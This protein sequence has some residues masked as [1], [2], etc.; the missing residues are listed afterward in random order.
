MNNSDKA[1]EDKK[2]Q[3]VKISDDIRNAAHPLYCYL[4]LYY[5]YRCNFN[6]KQYSLAAQ[7]VFRTFNTLPY[8]PDTTQRVAPS[9][10][11]DML[12]KGFEHSQLYMQQVPYDIPVIIDID[13][14]HLYV[15]V[16]S[17]ITWISTTLSRNGSVTQQ[18][19][20]KKLI[21]LFSN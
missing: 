7:G 6:A 13:Y 18:Q 15:F 12:L 11:R 2:K 8:L 3:L 5:T 19:V 4:K 9:T 16:T 1:L 17:Y 20:T 14:I 21:E 10:V